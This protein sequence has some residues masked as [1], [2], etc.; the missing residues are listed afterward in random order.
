MQ[1]T[2]AV[3]SCNKTDAEMFRIIPIAF[4]GVTDQVVSRLSV[5][6]IKAYQI[7]IL[8]FV[9]TYCISK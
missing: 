1:M 8:L 6:V 5:E 9:A 7:N 2:V 3:I 4:L